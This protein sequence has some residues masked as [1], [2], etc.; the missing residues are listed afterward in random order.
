[1]RLLTLQLG[2]VAFFKRFTHASRKLVH[3]QQQNN[4]PII[5]G[6]YDCQPLWNS[7]LD[8]V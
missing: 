6:V 2:T 7:T 1:M 3:H 5:K 8:I 4:L